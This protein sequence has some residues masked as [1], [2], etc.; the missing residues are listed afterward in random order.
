MREPVRLAVI[1]AGN[2]GH[3]VYARWCARHPEEARVV[4]VADPDET[5][6]NRLGADH[7]LPVSARHADW[8]ALVGDLSGIDAVL[9]TT[10]DRAHV[11]PTEAAL[12]AGVDVL[13]E[14]PIAPDEA[15]VARVRAAAA[16]SPATVTVAHVLRYTSFFQT[17]KALVDDGVIGRLLGLDHTENVGYWHFA[18]S[19][20]RGNWRRA[21]EAAPMLLAKACHDLDLLRWL[22]DAPCTSVASAGSLTHFH[23]GHAPE[24]APEHCLD[25]CPV[26]DTCPF[27]AGRFYVDALA[28]WDDWP[29][30][31]ITDDPSPQ[32]RLAVLGNGPYGRCV[33]RCDNDAVDH[34][35]AT[36]TF[37]GGVFATLTVTAFSEECTRT[38]RLLGTRGEV[39]GHLDSGEITV[40]R[41]LPA[42]HIGRPAGARGVTGAPPPKHPPAAEVLHRGAP[43]VDV[44]T[45]F[46][47][48]LGHAGGDDGLM[49]DFVARLRQRRAGETP[50]AARTSLEESLH[51]HDMAFAAERSRVT[52]RTVALDRSDV[53]DPST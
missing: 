24:G 43:P 4:A 13:L 50:Q 34:Q 9:V 52:G 47:A 11:E 35:I 21:D 7:D 46:G 51:S 19:Y 30:P 17:V 48:F 40:R 5:R 27:H 14:K 25:G 3:G 29:I 37:A 53:L 32:G 10:P 28:G 33:Y 1:G 41:F 12:A 49:A 23:R 31:V 16:A 15:G 45:P 2:R 18:H 38:V 22:A 8:R 26:E 20:V 44:R 42:P 6:R 36:L 39:R